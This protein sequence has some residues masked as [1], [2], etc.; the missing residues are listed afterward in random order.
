MHKQPIQLS[1]RDAVRAMGCC[2]ALGFKGWAEPSAIRYGVVVRPGKFLLGDP[3]VAELSCVASQNGVEA[4]T[5][6]DGSLK[7]ELKRLHTKAEPLLDFPN[8]TVTHQGSIEVRTRQTGR[9]RLTVGRRLQR[10]FELIRIFPRW[11][12]DTG[13]YDFSYWLGLDEHS[14]HAGPARITITSGPAAISSL[15][16]LLA[17]EDEGVRTRAAGLLHRMTAHVTGYSAESSEESRQEAADRWWAWWR[18]KGNEMRWN[19]RSQGATFGEYVEAGQQGRGSFLGGLT[20]ERRGFEKVDAATIASI[21]VEW[22]NSPSMGPERLRGKQWVADERVTYPG[23]EIMVAPGPEIATRMAS[24]IAQIPS[25][26]ASAPI[27]LGTATRML[28]QRYIE[29][30]SDLEHQAAKSVAL[31]RI[32]AFAAGML[33]VLDPGRTPIGA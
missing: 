18:G 13:E 4:F 29:P 33:D 17:H 10:R 20:Y 6:E 12:L 3:V 8:R 21:L 31:Q 7:L 26:Q 14:E 25:R 27:I 1:R 28:D 30:L 23:E 5:F 9:E 11:I 2:L 16:A 22:L 32:G 15:F 19:Y 24:A